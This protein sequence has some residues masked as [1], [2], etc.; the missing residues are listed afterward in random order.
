MSLL[1]AIGPLFESGGPTVQGPPPPPSD[2][3][4]PGLAGL[5]VALTIL[6]IAVRLLARVAGPRLGRFARISA[7]G[8]VVGNALM[9]LA[10]VL[11]PDRPAVVEIERARNHGRD[12]AD[13]GDDPRDDE[14][15]ARHRRKP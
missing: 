8:A 15:R 9:E 2:S 11:Q 14:A 4:P 10:A 7:F 12:D 1:A 6:A 5:V 13:A 3:L